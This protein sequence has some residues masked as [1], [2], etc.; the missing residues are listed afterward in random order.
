MLATIDVLS[1]GRLIVGCGRF[2]RAIRFERMWSLLGLALSIAY[3]TAQR[4][5]HQQERLSRRYKDG[6][7]DLSWLSLSLY[8]LL[9]VGGALAFSENFWVRTR[10]RALRTQNQAAFGSVVRDARPSPAG[11]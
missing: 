7:K 1:N 4:E 3:S 8:F 2:L 9:R 11:L 10:A 5:L 6:R